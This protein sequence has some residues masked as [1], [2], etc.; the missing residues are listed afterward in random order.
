MQY[1]RIQ[2]YQATF[3]LK[4]LCAL[5]TKQK[6]KRLSVDAPPALCPPCQ[7][8]CPKVSQQAYLQCMIWFDV[9]TSR[10][11]ILWLHGVTSCDTTCH[12]REATQVNLSETPKITVLN[13]ATLTFDL[14]PMT[15]D[16]DLRTHPRYYLGPSSYQFL[17]SYLQ[18]F[19]LESA[20]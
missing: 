15:Y 7:Y 20:N 1:I 12:D 19:S 16:L 18:P 6:W 11:Y 8:T 2:L 10:C 13:M 3:D 4:S 9:V 14:W 17:G 5:S